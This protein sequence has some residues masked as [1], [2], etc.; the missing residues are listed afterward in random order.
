MKSIRH[1]HYWAT[2]VFVVFLS[3]GTTIR[4]QDPDRYRPPIR[5]SHNVTAKLPLTTL[6]VVEGSSD[7]LVKEL[8]GIIILGHES[9]V[10]DPIKAFEGLRIHPA[11]DLT[12][13][14]EDAFK[15]SIRGYLGGPVSM[16]RLNE[17]ARSIVWAYRDMQQPVVDV[18]IPPGQDITDG[19]IQVVVTES[20]IG[21]IRF[22]GN[23]HFDTCVLQQQTWLSTG[24]RI[25][26]P[27]I[28]DELVWFNKNPYRS[29]D[30]KLVPGAEAATTDVVFQVRDENPV[31]YHISYADNGPRVAAQERLSVGFDYANF[32][33]KDRRLSYQ[34]T[35]D[36]HL[37][38][39]VNVHSLNYEAPI[40]ENRDSVSLFATWGDIDTIFDTPGG[41]RTA[42]SGNYWQVSGRYH[43]TLCED[44]CR[45]D[46]MHFGIDLKGADNYADF[47]VFPA[48]A[49]GP[50]VHI[51]NFMA[52]ISSE[53]NYADGVT[54]YG[55]DIFASPGSLLSNNHSRDLKRIRR[56]A[57][58]TYAYTR[59]YVES[60][61]SV[62]CHCDLFFRL[63]G[64]LSTGPLMPTEQLGFGGYNSVRGYDARTL[65]GDNGYILN[66]EYRTKP[67][68]GCLDGKQ[69]S[70]VALAFAD[71]AQQD[72]WSAG[73]IHPD[74]EFFASVG[75]GVRYMIDPN[76]NVRLD[77]GLPLT[78]VRGDQR[79][80][81]GRLHIGATLMY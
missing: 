48:I 62:N 10:Q 69:T 30:V 49:S 34:Y 54:K 45:L 33:G 2:A 38:G 22:E 63:T 58:S 78:S 4:A 26:V 8:K 43:H 25:F 80:Q 14:R 6:Q 46:R 53:Q 31:S 21:N 57:Q 56:E 37:S 75:A 70:F 17:L 71:I 67:V 35:T 47:G 19:V 29:V 24:Q 41:M 28:E 11:A 72:N 76:L 59:A 42:R 68:I 60:L 81:N 74:E 27:T 15:D 44:T 61:H 79:N 73:G 55:V 16:R 1:C 12:V 66:T 40:F 36:A 5:P 51:V 20:T 32:S 9:Q 77:Y 13:A 18:N 3:I 52:G 39:T 7:V 65:N 64:Q 50:E 23:C